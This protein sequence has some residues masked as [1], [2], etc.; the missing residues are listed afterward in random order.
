MNEQ[1][2]ARALFRAGLL[3]FALVALV[4]LG[5][6]LKWVLVQLFAA[7]I[8]AAAMAPVVTRLSDTE[9]TLPWNWRP[10]PAVLVAL[11]YVVFGV[12]VLVLGT[13]LLKVVLAES[14]QLMQRAPDYAL[15]I[16]DWYAA[17]ARRWLPFEQLDL[18][19]ALGGTSGLTQWAV[20]ALGQVLGAAGLLL[21]VFGG[22]INVIF[23]LFM[24]LYLTVDAQSMCEYL[25]V[26]LPAN[27]RQR[28]LRI[29]SDISCRLGRW[30]LGELV[31]CVIVG[32]G[33][34]IGLGLIGVP[35]TLLLALVW[36]VSVLIPGIGPFIAATP[37][38]VLGF[39]AGPTTGVLAASFALV[40]SQLENN[41]LVPRVMGHA[42][43]L[44]PLVVLV[45]LL[46]GNQ[47]LGL[48]GALFAIPLAA[49]LAVVVD[50]LHQE[51]LRA[52]QDAQV[53]LGAPVVKAQ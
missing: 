23:V 24:A 42:V 2:Q 20:S 45:A 1:V 19:D 39:M 26:F 9:R 35:G 27:Y 13:V 40:W 12:I 46:V 36:A 32:T 41:V 5:L 14:A 44:N 7:A 33:A 47:L 10:P 6:Q 28:V 30:V 52:D 16:Q 4:L 43:K 48:A 53:E 18:F 50:E 21:A 11:I 15:T 25:L 38:I 29:V 8:I 17:L 3:L 34:G 51:R 37:T 49:A 31:L 22:A